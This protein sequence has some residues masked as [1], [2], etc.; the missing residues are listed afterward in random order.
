Y[1]LDSSFSEYLD[2]DESEDQLP[3][4]IAL[5]T[6]PIKLGNKTLYPDYEITI[7]ERKI[8]IVITRPRYYDDDLSI[9]RE[10]RE[11]GLSLEIFCTISNKEKCPSGA[12]CFK[13]TIDWYKLKEY[14]KSK[15]EKKVENYK[16]IESNGRELDEE[17]KKKIITHLRNLYPD[18]QAMLDYLDFMGIEPVKILQD[19]GFIIEWKG[20][21]LVIKK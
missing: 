12:I 3:Q 5:T 7:D 6:N 2:I 15:Y 19:A 11:N 13:D 18:T 8:Y 21:R 1:I 16:S 4:E 14:L 10:C 9:V 20:L 17:M